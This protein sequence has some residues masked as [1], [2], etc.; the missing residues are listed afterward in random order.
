[1]KFINLTN[2]TILSY[3]RSPHL[4]LISTDNKTPIII[5]PKQSRLRVKLHNENP[6]GKNQTTI[7]PLAKTN[8]RTSKQ[9]HQTILY[10]LTPR[11]SVQN[12]LKGQSS[13]YLGD[14]D[15]NAN[16]LLPAGAHARLYELVAGGRPRGGAVDDDRGDRGRRV[17][18]EPGRRGRPTAT[19]P[20]RRRAAQIQLAL[21]ALEAAA[22]ADAAA[23]VA[24]RPAAGLGRRRCGGQQVFHRGA[25][26]QGARVVGRLLLP[27]SVRRGRGRWSGV[28]GGVRQGVRQLEG[29]ARFRGLDRIVRLLRMRRSQESCLVFIVLWI[30]GEVRGSKFRFFGEK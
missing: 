25:P 8:P 2:K 17:E 4:L 6:I 28:V 12:N 14:G 11:Q 24:G 18:D 15:L 7:A 5:R 20:A 29:V 21:A 27:V 26:R 16:G 22:A 9:L 19:A 1:M 3:Y 23:G 13:A 30:I 10:S